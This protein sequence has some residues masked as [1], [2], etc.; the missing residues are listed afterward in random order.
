LLLEEREVCCYE[1]S[2]IPL[3]SGNIFGKSTIIAK[4]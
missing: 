4:R 3:E 1:L 2:E